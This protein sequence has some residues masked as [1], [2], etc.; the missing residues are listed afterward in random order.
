MSVLIVG[1]SY[2]S[3]MGLG[4]Y[5]GLKNNSLNGNIPFLLLGLGVDD[6]FVLVRGRLWLCCVLCFSNSCMS[7]P[8]FETRTRTPL[9]CNAHYIILCV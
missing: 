3:A 4:A 1:L 8:L 9:F 6:A 5:L 7:L 2:G